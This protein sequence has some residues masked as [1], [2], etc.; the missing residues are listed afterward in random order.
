[1]PPSGFT[2]RQ[3]AKKRSSINC[4]TTTSSRQFV[5][6]RPTE[7]TTLKYVVMTGELSINGMVLLCFPV[8]PAR[9][10]SRPIS[11]IVSLQYGLKAT[12]H[13]RVGL[14][15]IVRLPVMSPVADI[16][17]RDRVIGVA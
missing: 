5:A 8:S 2:S 9:S 17:V 11:G 10:S 4:T 16:Q 13:G 14:Q 6:L 15:R 1:M 7:F 3:V 12:R